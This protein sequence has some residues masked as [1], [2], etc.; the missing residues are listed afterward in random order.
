L[1]VI[2][3]KVSGKPFEQMVAEIIDQP[4]AMKN[5]V[6]HL[7]PMQASR[8]ATVYDEG[9]NETPPWDFDAMAAIGSL[10]STL[11]DMVAYVV[12][13]MNTKPITPVNKAIDLTHQTT[14][15]NDDIKVG[16]GWH[17]V[18][19]VGKEYYF[20][21]GGTGGSSSYLAISTAKNFAVIILSNSVEST[22]DIGAG[23]LTK[24][25]Q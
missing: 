16:L 17:I 19:I 10:K 13:N 21:T 12:A 11:N 5:T 18:N 7:F 24:L 14:F 15:K 9:G 22:D 6:Q 4:L 8:F 3:E 2:L 1:G 23:L 25:N 20:H